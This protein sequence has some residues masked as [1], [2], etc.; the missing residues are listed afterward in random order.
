MSLNQHSTNCH[1]LNRRVT[2]GSHKNFI[3]AK[4]VGLQKLNKE[5]MQYFSHLGPCSLENWPY[6]ILHDQLLIYT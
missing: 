1:S 5:K 4:V 2:S 6:N 3:E